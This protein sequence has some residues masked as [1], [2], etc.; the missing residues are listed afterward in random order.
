M[1]ST[2]NS[3]L[4]TFLFSMRLIKNNKIIKENKNA[5]R[6]A[7]GTHQHGNVDQAQ[8]HATNEFLEIN[9]FN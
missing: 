4:S 8:L 6:L 2:Q 1:W 5:Y 9:G 7:E 3:A